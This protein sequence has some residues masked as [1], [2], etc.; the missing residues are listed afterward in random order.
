MSIFDFLVVEWFV[1]II[2]ELFLGFFGLGMIVFG[3][4]L[5]LVYCMIVEC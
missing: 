3:G 5:L 4:V 2:R 1:F